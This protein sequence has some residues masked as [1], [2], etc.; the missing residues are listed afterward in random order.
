M[1][2]DPH[3]VHHSLS[4]HMLVDGFDFVIDLDKSSGNRFHDA[5]SGNQHH[6][7]Q[8]IDCFVVDL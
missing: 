2:V 1:T 5:K 7:A 4:K 6:V 3:H 8:T